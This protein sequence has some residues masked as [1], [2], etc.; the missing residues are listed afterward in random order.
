MHANRS[1]YKLAAAPRDV[2]ASTMQR[3]WHKHS[4]RPHRLDTQ[5][6]SN[7]PDFETKAADMIDLYLRP[8]A[9]AVVFCIDGDRA[10][11]L[12]HCERFG[13]QADALY[14]RAQQESEAD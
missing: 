12:H 4:V 7:D 1:S 10:R 6:V 11:H 9:Q 14:P 5:M 2:G 8:P 3:I 13:P